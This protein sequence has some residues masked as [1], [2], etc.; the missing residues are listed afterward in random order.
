[1]VVEQSWL[2]MHAINRPTSYKYLNGLFWEKKLTKNLFTVINFITKTQTS[3][4]TY[5]YLRGNSKHD[6]VKKKKKIVTT[7][8]CSNSVCVCTDC[9]ANCKVKNI[10]DAFGVRKKK[11]IINF[12]FFIK[13]TTFVWGSRENSVCARMF[14]FSFH[15]FFFYIVPIIVFIF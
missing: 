6:I 10:N 14:F 9:G 11:L 13:A 8:K 7:D 5:I 3:I 2:I 4:K 15:V 1:M 12:L